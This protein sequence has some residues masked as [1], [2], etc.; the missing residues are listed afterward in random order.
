MERSKIIIVIVLCIL[1]SMIFSIRTPVKSSK[2]KLKV[3][4]GTVYL[5]KNI[6]L[7]PKAR[8]VLDKILP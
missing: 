7:P 6:G 3:T 4:Q 8:K 5:N 2:K 1:V